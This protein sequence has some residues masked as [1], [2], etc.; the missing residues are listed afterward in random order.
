MLSRLSWRRRRL[1]KAKRRF[2]RGRVAAARNV[3]FSRAAPDMAPKCFRIQHAMSLSPTPVTERLNRAR[4][5]LRMGVPVVVA[6]H[7]GRT[8]LRRRGAGCGP[9]G[10]SAPWGPPVLALTAHRAATLKA[11][12]YDGDVARILIPPDAGIGWIAGDG[13]SGG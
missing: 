4:A 2:S 13:R 12:A 1:D 7:R 8:G 3:S 10:R 9:A 6:W 5:D 11:R